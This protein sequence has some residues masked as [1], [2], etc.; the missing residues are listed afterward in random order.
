MDISAIHAV[1]PYEGFDYKSYP[2]DLQGWGSISPAFNQIIADVRPD[3]II[4]VGAWKGGSTANMAGITADLG[5]ATKILSIDTWLGAQEFWTDQRDPDRYLS[6]RLKHGWP[7]VYYQ[8]LA[9]MMHCGI[10]DRVIPFPQ[11]SLVAAR[12]L[13]A[14][15]ITAPLIYIDASHDFADVLADLR[16]YYPLV[17]AGGV[18]F[19]DDFNTWIGVNNALLAFGAAYDVLEGRY[20]RIRK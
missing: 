11:T 10:E 12:W 7:Q 19:G 5:L 1:N 13:E 14:R 20:W 4:E 16:A 15:R 2:L 3:F 17:S 18:L 8:F 6:L 9:N